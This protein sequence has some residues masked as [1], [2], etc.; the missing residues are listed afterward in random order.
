MFIVCLH[1]AL[2][3]ILFLIT[4]GTEY[5]R[6]MH[7]FILE[8]ITATTTTTTNYNNNND[9][10]NNDNNS[11]SGSTSTTTTA[12]AECTATSV[13]TTT[14]TESVEGNKR[15][16]SSGSSSQSVDLSDEEGYFIVSKK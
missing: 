5:Y 16:L 3:F 1:Y 9:N 11:S 10:N 13:T 15:D 2:S 6:R 7:K 8:T 4:I 14:N 12:S